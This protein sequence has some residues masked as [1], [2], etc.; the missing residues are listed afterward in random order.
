VKYGKTIAATAL[1]LTFLP[2]ACRQQEQAVVG[3][4]ENAAHSAQQV[5]VSAAANAKNAE[6]HAQAAASESATE[7]A[8][9][10]HIPVPTKSLYVSVHDPAEWKNPF[11]TVTAD[12]IDLHVVMADANTSPIGAGTML[13]PEAARKQEIQIH[14]GDLA[15]A[16]IAL[17]DGAWR[18]GR[19]VAIAESPEAVRKE[20]PIIRR[21]MEAAIQKLND[22]GIVVE[23][24][25]SR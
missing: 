14:R 3:V 9:L 25:P 24:W 12:S 20:R 19:V 8:A 10:A 16:L 22:L 17:P 21:N 5:A 13:R 2:T 6:L 15:E 7:R 4:A 18:Y 23:E 11:L 1:V